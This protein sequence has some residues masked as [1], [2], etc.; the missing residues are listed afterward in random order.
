MGKAGRPAVA[1]SKET[2]TFGQLASTSSHCFSDVHA[3]VQDHQL[4]AAAI[5]TATERTAA[6]EAAAIK[7]QSAFRS[8]LAR[9]ALCALRGMVKLQAMV[10]GQLVRR[11]ADMTL[12]RMQ[13]L[14]VVDRGSEENVKVVEVDNG[15]GGDARGKTRG[16]GRRSTCCSAPPVSRAPAKAELYQKVSPTPSALT[17]A[18][19]R[20]M[21]GR[22]EDYSFSAAASE[23]SG[24]RHHRGAT[25]GG[26]H[27]AA[28]LQL[29]PNYMS[30]TES[31]RAKARSQSAPRQRHDQASASPSPS[32]SC[33]EWTMP[34][35]DR[36]RR[37]SLDPRDLAGGGARMERCASQVRAS[38]NSACP[39][40][41]R[42]D[43]SSASLAG[44]ECGSAGTVVTAATAARVTS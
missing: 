12:R 18:S 28:A 20:T 32:P 11:Q 6:E 3:V 33:G 13:A 34:S 8:Y 21:S 44:S 41:V 29:F 26:D 31:S 40:A 39:W 17:D 19:A 43:R 30:N 38:A 1:T 23:A 10:R 4:A 35:C 15:G 27:P 9:K 7:I 37:A 36:R 25:G 16:C 2:G 22:F 42:L 24:V 5:A 14:E